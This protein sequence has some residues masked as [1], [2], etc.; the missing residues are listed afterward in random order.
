MTTQQKLDAARA[1]LV[2]WESADAFQG[3]DDDGT[4]TLTITDTYQRLMAQR[5]AWLDAVPATACAG[6]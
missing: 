1:L 3:A 6:Q 2:A 5:T 4:R